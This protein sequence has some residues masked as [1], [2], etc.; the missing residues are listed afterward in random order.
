MGQVK[1]IIGEFKKETNTWKKVW[2]QLSVKVD[3][4]SDEIVECNDAPY[5]EHLTV[6]EL[7]N[8]ISYI[9]FFDV[10]NRYNSAYTAYSQTLVPE[11]KAQMKVKMDKAI[12]S[13]YKEIKKN[14]K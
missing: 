4:K 14:L 2:N 8:G 10:Y 5:V 13:F 6:T 1:T 7:E 3:W 12:S 9:K 11:V